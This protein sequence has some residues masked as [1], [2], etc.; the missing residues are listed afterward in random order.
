MFKGERCLYRFHRGSSDLYL[1]YPAK[2]FEKFK[3]IDFKGEKYLV[4]DPPEG[5]LDY[6]WGKDQWKIPCG[7][8]GGINPFVEIPNNT[9]I[10]EIK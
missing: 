9:F 10:P 7:L 4:P 6:M 1:S 3:E 5:L 8:N 2:F